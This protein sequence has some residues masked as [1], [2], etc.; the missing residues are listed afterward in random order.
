MVVGASAASPRRCVATL[1]ASAA[2]LSG[3][4]RGQAMPTACCYAGIAMQYGLCSGATAGVS[5][6]AHFRDC[7][8]HASEHFA[9]TTVV[10]EY[11]LTMAEKY[12]IFVIVL[13]AEASR[14][15]AEVGD[16]PLT[17]EADTIPAGAQPELGYLPFELKVSL[18][19]GRTTQD[20]CPA[21]ELADLALR[22]SL[23]GQQ[24]RKP[25]R[26][27]AGFTFGIEGCGRHAQ[28]VSNLTFE[29]LGYGTLQFDFVTVRDSQH[30]L[31]I[32]APS[33]GDRGP[34]GDAIGFQESDAVN[35]T[36][37]YFGDVTGAMGNTYGL[38]QNGSR[39]IG[40]TFVVEDPSRHVPD[41][42]Y[43]SSGDGYRFTWL[44]SYPQEWGSAEHGFKHLDATSVEYIRDVELGSVNISECR[45]RPWLSR[46][47]PI[48][49]GAG[50][51]PS[52]IPPSLELYNAEAAARSRGAG[53]TGGPLSDR[54]RGS[55]RTLLASG[56]ARPLFGCNASDSVFEYVWDVA[57][58]RSAVS[59][60][61]FRWA[62]AS[63]PV[64]AAWT[65]KDPNPSF[66][67]NLQSSSP[68]A[69]FAWTVNDTLV[70][71]RPSI[72][73]NGS[74]IPAQTP[75]VEADSR[76]FDLR[77]LPATDPACRVGG[78]LS[79]SRARRRATPAITEEVL[80]V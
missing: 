9:N 47:N 1:L 60:S 22:F 19:R 15:Q 4:V 18:P 58:A 2:L 17:F 76:T 36:F 21:F 8:R 31:S 62:A 28:T 53:R 73:V 35:C 23:H 14:I 69:G 52:A 39:A 66:W 79:G 43:R 63:Q 37:R 10:G 42:A 44:G 13:D 71:L 61:T 45:F 38:T 68:D 3:R 46:S 11:N 20:P 55:A 26:A 72:V 12:S 49:A 27:Y 34:A 32:E 70:C 65:G 56:G 41:Y 67:I 64:P 6:W 77:F 16:L 7:W 74:T 30:I 25:G 29:A 51:R 57:V 40:S 48:F 50:A 78:A 24:H 33:E 75:T 54:A 59:R 80:V 5:T